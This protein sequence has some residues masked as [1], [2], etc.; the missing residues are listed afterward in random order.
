MVKR[1]A[2]QIFKSFHNV[3]QISIKSLNSSML[4]LRNPFFQIIIPIQLTD[5]SYFYHSSEFFE[6]RNE[7]Q[8]T[9]HPVLKT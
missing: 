7:W 4:N 5:I 3:Y 2:I 9:R 8:T 6:L 1:T